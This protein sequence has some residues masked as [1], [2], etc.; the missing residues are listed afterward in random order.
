MASFCI[1]AKRFSSVNKLICRSGYQ[2]YRSLKLFTAQVWRW[3]RRRL[4]RQ[5]RRDSCLFPQWGIR[6]LSE[7]C[8]VATATDRLWSVFVQLLHWL[9]YA[10]IL[11]KQYNLPMQFGYWYYMSWT[12]TKTGN[13]DYP[14]IFTW[15]QLVWIIE[16]GLYHNISHSGGHFSSVRLLPLPP[17][18]PVLASLV[19]RPSHAPV[20]YHK[21]DANCSQRR[22]GN[23]ASLAHKS[24]ATEGT[25]D[26]GRGRWLQPHSK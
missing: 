19:S 13:L 15:S 7:V 12:K 2:T 17:G 24:W 11:K 14:N 20:F 26:W 21:Q 5:C 8:T 6:M 10:T 16:A 9:Q 4:Q 3:G 18:S 25:W 1:T 23:K 22:P